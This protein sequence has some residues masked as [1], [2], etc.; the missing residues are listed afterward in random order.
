MAES[1]KIREKRPLNVTLENKT[2][3]DMF[4]NTPFRIENA[5]WQR[6]LYLICRRRVDVTNEKMCKNWNNKKTI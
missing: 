3:Y 2:Q 5:E 6:Y 1:L 4:P